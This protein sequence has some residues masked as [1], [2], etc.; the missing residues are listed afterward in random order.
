MFKFF[1]VVF[2]F[3]PIF[4]SAQN[5]NDE[6]IVD[7]DKA[8][9]SQFAREVA[10]I[11]KINILL[12]SDVVDQQVSLNIRQPIN[13]KDLYDYFV[14]MLHLHNMCIV[15]EGNLHKVMGNCGNVKIYK[16]KYA[17]ADDIAK[18]INALSLS[19][20][21]VAD[22][23]SNSLIY[24]NDLSNDI[25][26]L[27]TKLDRPAEQVLIRA[28]ILELSDDDINQLGVQWSFGNKDGY[29]VVNLNPKV[30]LQSFLASNIQ[31][32][33]SGAAIGA[34]STSSDQF[35]G[36][37]LFALNQVTSSKLLSNP[38]ILVQNNKSA[39][40]LVGQNI[41]VIDGTGLDKNGEP[42]NQISRMDVGIKLNVT[43]QIL[44][45]ESVK[46]MVNQEVSNVIS[47]SDPNGVVTNKSQIDTTIVAKDGQ[48]IVL[49]GL[50][51][52]DSVS[53][54]QAVPGLSKMP[55]IG[56]AFK[57]NNSS[58]RKSNLVIFIQPNIINYHDAVLPKIE[59]NGKINKLVIDENG[60]L[61]Q[62]TDH[63][64]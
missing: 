53:D 39:S 36:A 18:S 2:L 46:L 21:V 11:S 42:F 43:P 52:D 57:S 51:R 25:I 60:D 24:K 37:V 59:R 56:K 28:V 10:S 64:E 33:Q 27:I 9:L 30:N 55:L 5:Y 26:S 3:L 50:M 47:T 16:L 6:W 23:Y 4:A 58:S 32:F 17:L 54:A 44:E 49:G 15:Q 48:T 62:L 45:N 13:A 63:Q 1:S 29:G 61:V 20:S 7:I 8:S 40:M 31:L 34:K 12:S 19:N 14:S 38:T 41:P 22:T 35:V